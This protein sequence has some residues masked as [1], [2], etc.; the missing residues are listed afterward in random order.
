MNN[1]KVMALLTCLGGST[2]S[3]GME[4]SSITMPPKIIVQHVFSKNDLSDFAERTG[5]VQKLAEQKMTIMGVLGALQDAVSDYTASPVVEPSRCYT[6]LAKV[7]D[8]ALMYDLLEKHPQALC[9]LA[10]IKKL[11]LFEMRNKNG[12]KL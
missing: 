3:F 9:E 2:A 11:N 7:F 8:P 4:W 6:T 5:I 10:E 12:S 1:F